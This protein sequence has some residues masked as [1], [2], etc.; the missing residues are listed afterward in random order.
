MKWALSTGVLDVDIGA[1]V[2]EVDRH[3]NVASVR[4]QLERRLRAGRHAIDQGAPRQQLVDN[5]PVPALGSGVQRPPR[6]GGM[7]GYW[8]TGGGLLL[9]GF[10]NLKRHLGHHRADN[11]DAD[12]NSR[13]FDATS[14]RHTFRQSRGEPRGR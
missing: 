14:A 7:C 10:F 4:R 6:D 1:K 8:E 11:N 13:P 2:D 3:L 9:W 12:N 5:R